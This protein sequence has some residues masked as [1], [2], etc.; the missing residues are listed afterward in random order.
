MRVLPVDPAAIVPG[1]SVITEPRALGQRW[2]EVCDGQVGW[3]GQVQQDL[4]A[5]HV[6]ACETFDTAGVRLV[7]RCHPFDGFG[8][9][10]VHVAMEQ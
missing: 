9:P 3:V 8:V 1:S 6:V 7:V 10:R 2:R 5:F 4:V